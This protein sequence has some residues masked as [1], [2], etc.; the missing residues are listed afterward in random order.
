LASELVRLKP[1]V[2]VTTGM[3]VVVD[4]INKAHALVSYDLNPSQA[5]DSRAKAIASKNELD[6]RK[7]AEGLRASGIAYHDKRDFDRAIG[8]FDEAIRLDP[9]DAKAYANRGI[10][11]GC[12]GDYDRAI[13]DFEEAIRLSP[14]NAAFFGV[15]ATTYLAKGDYDRA[16][17]DFD[18]AI[19][20]NP[21]FT[22]A[23]ESRAEAIARRKE[24]GGTDETFAAAEN[25][26]A[27]S[28]ILSTLNHLQANV[29][30]AVAEAPD[31]S[32]AAEAAIRQIEDSE[33]RCQRY[34]ADGQRL[35]ALLKKIHD[36]VGGAVVGYNDNGEVFVHPDLVREFET[37]G[38]E[39]LKEMLHRV[40]LSNG[41]QHGTH[42]KPD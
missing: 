42:P 6:G 1:D 30:R 13:A 2:I 36:Q 24:L 32:K 12:K 39:G 37:P 14:R 23:I 21:H 28:S 9:N 34:E 25:G 15:R 4:S 11:Y 33:A 5:I 29:L 17:A 16:I 40:A 41:G 27:L 3:G 26:S 8:D 35:S 18:E 10:A 7:S 19:R 31:P 20:L 22:E 38:N